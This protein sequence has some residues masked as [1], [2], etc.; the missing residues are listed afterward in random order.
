MEPGAEVP[1]VKPFRANP[2]FA[3]PANKVQL[4]VGGKELT[5]AVKPGD[6]GVTFKVYE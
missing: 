5:K 1:G 2:G 4:N 3:F 6:L